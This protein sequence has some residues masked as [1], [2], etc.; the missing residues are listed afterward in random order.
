[1]IGMNPLTPRS[2]LLGGK[3]AYKRGNSQTYNDIGVNFPFKL[4]KAVPVEANLQTFGKV[5][6]LNRFC[7]TCEIK[8]KITEI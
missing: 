2:V 4:N 6:I 3:R 7:V 5:N 8:Q 1:M